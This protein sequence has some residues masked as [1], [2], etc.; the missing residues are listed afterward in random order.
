MMKAEANYESDTD[1]VSKEIS[2]I[3]ITNLLSPL[4]GMEEEIQPL[5]K[6]MLMQIT[7]QFTP[8]SVQM[9][10]SQSVLNRKVRRKARM[11]NKQI[12]NFRESEQKVTRSRNNFEVNLSP[13]RTF[14]NFKTQKMTT[15]AKLVVKKMSLAGS[16]DMMQSPHLLRTFTETS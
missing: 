7:D 15:P 5:Q 1:E 9:V 11:I 10:Y 16:K 12:V 14:T 13:L 4:K 8:Y 3:K 2:K 6:G